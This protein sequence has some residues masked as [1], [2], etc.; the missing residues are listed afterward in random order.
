MLDYAGGRQGRAT[1]AIDW[2]EVD[3]V[4]MGD[5]GVRFAAKCWVAARGGRAIA[6]R[7]PSGMIEEG[8]FSIAGLCPPATSA[9]QRVITLAPSNAEVVDALGAFERVIA[10]EDSS[11]HPPAVASVERLGPDLG[12]NL[13]RVA[14]LA[15]DLVLSSLS[16]PGMER[17][18][19]GLAVRGVPQL[20]LAPRSLAD[21][22]ADIRRAAQALG[23]GEIGEAVA[24]DMEAQEAALRAACSGEPTPVYLEWWPKPMFTP[25]QDCYSNELISLAGGRNV[26]GDRPGSSLEVQAAEV[27]AA[28]PAVCF[29]S[30]CGVAHDKL[31]PRNL[32]E[33]PGFEALP[34]ALQGR[35]Y[36]LD[37]AFSGRPGPRMLEA[38]RR[39]AAAIRGG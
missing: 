37:E 39:M 15:P 24:G 23:L 6:L 2:Q 13:D 22:R 5:A 16:V 10:C 18:V 19:T 9:A 31:D 25:G 30:W 3:A 26:F 1:F 27:V 7:G 29:V 28:D 38:A 12:P 20:V 32:I 35:V 17:V 11:D 21:V 14:E 34:A 36:R 4:A 33:R 8:P